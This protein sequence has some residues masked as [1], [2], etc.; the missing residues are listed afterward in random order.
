MNIAR[1]KAL[2]EMHEDKR[3]LVYMDTEGL[4]TIGIGFN[5]KRHGAK[6]RIEALG[7]D[8]SAVCSGRCLLEDRHVTELF[9]TDFIEAMQDCYEILDNFIELP[10]AVQMAVVDMRFN[11]GGAGLRKFKKFIAALE[12]FNYCAAV[13]EM[14]NSKWA[15]QVGNRALDDICLVKDYCVQ[16]RT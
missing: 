9:E 13:E 4:L 3:Y 2:I 16:E 15:G 8:Y 12:R 11:L 1:T 5:L 10:D 6:R 7:L 14:K